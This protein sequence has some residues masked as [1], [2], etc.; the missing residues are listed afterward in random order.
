M[1]PG[2]LTLF[3]IDF[4]HLKT[5]GHFKSIKKGKQIYFIVKIEPN[6]IR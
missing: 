6:E 5:F 3:F 4:L 2:F 1:F